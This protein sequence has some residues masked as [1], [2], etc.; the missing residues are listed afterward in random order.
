M[1][2]V[3]TT[4][5]HLKRLEW[6]SNVLMDLGSLASG[7]LPLFSYGRSLLMEEDAQHS[8]LSVVAEQHVCRCTPLL[9]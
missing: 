2:V 5:G 9:S 8:H 4:L 3:E 7:Q 6:R 1:N